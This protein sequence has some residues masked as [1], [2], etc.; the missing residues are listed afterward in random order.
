MP[1]DPKEEPKK[2]EEPR[3]VSHA[4]GFT[5]GPDGGSLELPKEKKDE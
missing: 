4:P 5:T 1:D 2:E 3:L